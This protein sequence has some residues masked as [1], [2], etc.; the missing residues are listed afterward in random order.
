MA[1]T[2]A[3]NSGGR[4]V[5]APGLIWPDIR[6]SKW[7]GGD[8]EGWEEGAVLAGWIHSAGLFAGR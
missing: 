6:D 1:E 8:K 5:R 2:A 7:I 4:V 3:G